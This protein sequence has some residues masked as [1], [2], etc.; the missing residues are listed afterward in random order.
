MA[1][2][3][4]ILGSGSAGNSILVCSDETFILVDAGFSARE[5]ERRLA[6]LGLQPSQ[7]AG[8]CV[9]HE[10]NDHTAGLR[11]LQKKHGIPLYANAGTIEALARSPGARDLRWNVFA[12][13]S[14]FPIGDLLVEAFS[15]P[16]DAYEPVGF[17]VSDGQDRVGVATDMGMATQLV[18]DRL[19]GCR[20]IVI[21]SNH[22]EQLLQA[23]E[24]PW[25]LKQRI[26]GR[27]GHLSNRLAADLLAGI[28]GP[29]LE[30]VFLT[31]LSEDCNRADL[32]LATVGGQLER[33][34]CAHVRLSLSY[35]DRVSE[36]WCA[37]VASTA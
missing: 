12:T 25:S 18:R 37:A 6:A 27:Q 14:S 35:P 23:A 5:T 13:G 15:V 22:D 9:T 34:G 17:V 19:A 33:V 26:M 4:C 21:E 29:H 2:Q 3:L 11:I 8:I 20:A 16:H 31:H 10:H 24:R 30:H 7:I 36:R 1:L 32:A 28:A